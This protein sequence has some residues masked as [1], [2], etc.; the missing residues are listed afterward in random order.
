VKLYCELFSTAS[1]GPAGPLRQTLFLS[2]LLPL[3]PPTASLYTSFILKEIDAIFNLC[4]EYLK[5]ATGNNGGVLVR[6]SHHCVEDDYDE[7]EIVCGRIH[8]DLV[9]REKEKDAVCHVDVRTLLKQRLGSCATSLG[10]Q[11]Y[12]DVLST[13]EP[14][15]L[16]QLQQLVA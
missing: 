1:Y 9:Q 8:N 10:Q 7:E 13:V 2:M 5:G 15:L 12:G 6:P 11:A 3:L 14:V 16:R 4:W